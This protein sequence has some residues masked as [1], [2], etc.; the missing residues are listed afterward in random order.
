M[1]TRSEGIILIIMLG[2]HFLRNK[3]WQHICCKT[4]SRRYPNYPP[5]PLASPGFFSWPPAA[6]LKN[7]DRS[8]PTAPSLSLCFILRFASVGTST[9]V[10]FSNLGVGRKFVM[11]I[12]QI[13]VPPADHLSAELCRGFLFVNLSNPKPGHITGGSEGGGARRGGGAARGGAGQDGTPTGRP[14]QEK[15]DPPAPQGIEDN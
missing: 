3:S 12:G 13:E 14:A 4:R 10:V 8:V 15:T 9:A 6:P 2:D 11:S 5:R 7:A 1:D